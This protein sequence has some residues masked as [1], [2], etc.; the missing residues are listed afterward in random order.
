MMLERIL[1]NYIKLHIKIKLY[2]K[3]SM[4]INNLDSLL[5]ILN[6]NLKNFIQ[7]LSQY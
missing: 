2:R 4:S 5:K 1:V 7:T 6:L 3:N